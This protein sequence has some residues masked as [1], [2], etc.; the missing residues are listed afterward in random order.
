MKAT[1]SIANGSTTRSDIEDGPGESRRHVGYL[2]QKSLL[3]EGLRAPRL[4]EAIHDPTFNRTLRT[5]NQR[6]V[7]ST[8]LNSLSH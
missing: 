5:V 8:L 6:S 3:N 2:P 7:R 1:S 4:P